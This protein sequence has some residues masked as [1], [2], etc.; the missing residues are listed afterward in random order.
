[1]LIS[2]S[3][4]LAA[5]A[6]AL[7][8]PAHAQRTSIKSSLPAS[9]IAFF[10]FPDLDKSVQELMDMPL[11]RMWG[12]KEIQ[13]F[14]A[15][16][17]KELGA[18]WEQGL[19]SANAAHE[20]GMLPFPPADLMRLRVYGATGALTGLK[21]A[22]NEDNRP[23]PE[24]GV[25]LH[26]DFG[27]S[28]P[29][30]KNLVAFG[31]QQLEAEAGG[32]L[33]KSESTAGNA[34]VT[35]WLPP[36]GPM[37]LHLAWLG[38][39]IVI[40]T[41][42]RDVS[43]AVQAVQGG[44]TLVAS[45]AYKTVASNLDLTDNEFELFV[46]VQ[47]AY[48][49]VFGV[50]EFAQDNAPGFPAELDVAKLDTALD[51]FGL[52]S[53]KAL[54]LTSSYHGNKCVTKSYVLAPAPE[55][56]GI[57]AGGAYDL[58][59]GLLQ[60]VPK[61]AT[62]CAASTFDMNAIWD[63]LVGAARAYDPDMT[64][65]ALGQLKSIEEKIGFTIHDDLFGSFGH[66]Y[67]SWGM[68]IQGIPGLSGGQLLSGVYL[69]NIRDQERLLK[70][71]RALT[72]MSDGMV[73]LGDNTRN[74]MTTYFLQINAPAPANLPINPFD[75]ITPVFAFEKDY[76][77][78]G[79]SKSD[80][81]RTIERMRKPDPDDSINGNPA[82]AKMLADLKKDRLTSVSFSDLR[83]SFDS[84][85]QTVY[86]FSYLIPDE[87]PVDAKELPDEG[88]F[89]SQ[90]LFPS[91][92]YSHTDGNGFSSTMVSPFGPEV[93]AIVVT[94]VAIGAGVATFTG[95]AGARRR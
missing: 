31:T 62:S 78:L 2:R 91:I 49:A 28:A 24:V 75:M 12:Q 56:K 67:A 69:I 10:T 79:F 29:I 33:T 66:Q 23:R 16:A 82:F 73:E 81:R 58:D 27:T 15:P 42:L 39:S 76:M 65:M 20:Q 89:L 59:I 17:L 92:G 54:G 83:A 47:N 95:M 77:V 14:L 50:L 5:S 19:A 1:M 57:V 84:L 64:E 25:L 93:V 87:V 34:T 85:Y 52:K 37:G 44:G 80:V 60:H 90:H 22:M 48:Q 26:L 70:S 9:S 41:L 18:Q 38:D 55:R 8:L 63:A 43:A 30:W 88:K 71:L 72:K 7:A 51:A 74:E 68:P 53:I 40:G 32:M 13:G 86:G 21:V 11:M 35:S 3:L 46:S 61:K 45:A 36:D 94:A 6:L 4:L